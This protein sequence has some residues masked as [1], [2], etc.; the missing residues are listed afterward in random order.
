MRL[1]HALTLAACFVVL[2]SAA[3][4]PR[5]STA[6][7]FQLPTSFVTLSSNGFYE[8]FESGVLPAATALTAV[9]AAT[10]LP[11][12]DAWCTI[13]TGIYSTVPYGGTFDFEM[14]F[15]PGSAGGWHDVRNAL[16]I[17][18]DGTGHPGPFRLDV[19]YRDLGENADAVD[20][21]WLSDDGAAWHQVTGVDGL[22]V[23]GLGWTDF[24]DGTSAWGSLSFDLLTTATAAGLNLFGPFY[25]AFAE[26]DN[27]P[28]GFEGVL[29]DDI[30]LDYV[31]GGIPT[32]AVTGLAA[33]QIATVDVQNM[34]LGDV[35]VIALSFTGGGPIATSF[36]SLFLSAPQLLLP[37]FAADAGGKVAFSQYVPPGTTGIP[38]WFQA[39]D[40]T[41]SLLSGG[42]ATTIQ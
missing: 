34:T 22:G 27:L 24:T 26:E 12:G 29:L 37:P 42:V 2:A 36:G 7:S 3:S 9:D 25:V 30:T 1:R 32:L 40:A 23:S 39:F 20:G 14:G 35:V 41:T 13:G 4:A 31:P 17:G 6:W 15:D 38:V 16:V 18:F 5:S 33:G 28:L 19:R 21:V 8:G 10:G 11:D